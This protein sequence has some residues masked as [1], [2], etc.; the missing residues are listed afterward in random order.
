MWERVS[1][2]LFQLGLNSAPMLFVHKENSESS[3]SK[4]LW[5]IHL[6]DSTTPL[7]IFKRGRVKDWLPSLYCRQSIFQSF[8]LSNIHSSIRRSPS[9]TK[10]SNPLLQTKPMN[11]GFHFHPS[12]RCD[13]HQNKTYTYPYSISKSDAGSKIQ[14]KQ[15]TPAQEFYQGIMIII[16]HG[17]LPHLNFI[18]PPANSS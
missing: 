2:V 18:K 12:N 5:D 11:T 1:C 14:E 3:M 16:P 4:L 9:Q 8:Y 10:P 7:S 15:T 6:I 17:F 13:R